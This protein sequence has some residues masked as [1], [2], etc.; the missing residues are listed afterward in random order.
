MELT[1]A[2]IFHPTDLSKGDEGAFAHALK[3]ALVAK[4]ELTLL[5]VGSQTEEDSEAEFPRI[6][7]FLERWGVVKPGAH[8][9]EV[10]QIGLN[11]R[12]VKKTSDEPV[13]AILRHIER[14][15]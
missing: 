10:T 3:L 1:F 12:K 2:K 11:I 6:R 15:K 13:Q 8:K 5:H 4:A 7:P 9:D 14:H